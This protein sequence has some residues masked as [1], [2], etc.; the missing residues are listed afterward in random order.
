MFFINKDTGIFQKKT[1]GFTLIELL[2]VIAIIGLI[3]TLGFLAAARYRDKAKEARIETVLVQ[4]RNITVTIYNERNSYL[5][6][7]KDGTLN[8]DKSVLGSLAIALATIKSEAHKF[9]G[10]DPTCYASITEYCVQSPLVRGGYYC[11]DSSGVAV[12]ISN[13]Y[14][15][16]SGGTNIKCTAP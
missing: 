16:A 2:V 9:S 13:A 4:V 1:N 12:R 14:C 11:V 8:D 15:G 3:A 6:I 7:C 5:D 10:S